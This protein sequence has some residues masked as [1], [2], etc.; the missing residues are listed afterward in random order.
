MEEITGG[1]NFING[2]ASLS[3]FRLLPTLL[4]DLNGNC[5][6]AESHPLVINTSFKNWFILLKMFTIPKLKK[7]LALL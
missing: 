4:P 1:G 5:F 3:V 7:I 2:A 6:I